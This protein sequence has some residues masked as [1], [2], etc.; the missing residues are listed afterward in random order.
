[1]KLP[2]RRRDNPKARTVTI[3]PPGTDLEEIANSSRYSGSPYHKDV[4]L[5]GQ[6][7]VR[8]PD[9]SICPRNLAGKQG[10]LTKWLRDAIKRGNIGGGWSGKFPKHVW[11]RKDDIIYEATYTGNGQYHGYPLEDYQAVRG[12]K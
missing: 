6:Q 3:P 4:P 8:R 10:Q 5:R 9:A 1:M 2:S 11:V 7:M 12:L